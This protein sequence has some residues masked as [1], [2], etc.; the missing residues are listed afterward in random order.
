FHA[1]RVTKRTPYSAIAGRAPWK[2]FQVMRTMSAVAAAAAA[3]ATSCR[4]RS[5]KRTRRPVKGR[6]AASGVSSAEDTRPLALDLRDRLLRAPEARLTERRAQQ[7]RPVTPPDGR[8][9]GTAV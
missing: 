3:P 6:R 1:M 4:A 9:T 7:P 2:T 8:G 5:P